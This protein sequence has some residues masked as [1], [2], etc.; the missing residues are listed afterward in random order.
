MKFPCIAPWNSGISFLRAGVNH[1]LNNVPSYSKAIPNNLNFIT[2]FTTVEICLMATY[3]SYTIYWAS[4]TSYAKFQHFVVLHWWI[5]GD[6]GCHFTN[7]LVFQQASKDRWRPF[8]FVI[9]GGGGRVMSTSLFFT[10]GYTQEKK[11]KRR[12]GGWSN[13]LLD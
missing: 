12:G 7:C 11:K 2:T 1:G 13:L 8:F 5:S 3:L 4:A 10:Q 9:S 6:S